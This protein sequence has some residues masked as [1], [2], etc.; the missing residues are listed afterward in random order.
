MINPIFNYFYKNNFSTLL[1]EFSIA[2]SYIARFVKMGKQLEI[3]IATTNPGKIAEFKAMLDGEIAWKSLG[4]FPNIIEVEETGTA[5][6][7]NAKLKAAGYAKQTGLLTL[8]DDSGLMIDALDG[9]PGVK[10]ARFSGVKNQDR[11]LID[12]KNIE[13][14]L[15]LLKDTP[16]NKRTAHFVCALCLA[17]PEKIIA[18]TQGILNGQITKTLLG[19]NG[20]GYD[21]I[22]WITEKDKTAA[23]LTSNEKNT[24]SHRAIA[25]KKMKKIIKNIRT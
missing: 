1:V 14:V 24:L 25:L 20:F 11:T 7:E 9:A 18:E 2:L 17:S 21:P 15:N 19:Q 23:Q 10:S 5:F 22:F 13:K 8:A 3:L 4:D 6:V 12:Y 16:E